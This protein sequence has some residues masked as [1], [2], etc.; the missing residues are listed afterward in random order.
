LPKEIS[1]VAE[2][3]IFGLRD[4]KGVEGVLIPKRQLHKMLEFVS[5][6]LRAL[7]NYICLC[8]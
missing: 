3:S 1:F 4:C 2:E 5:K 7:R 8:D 6:A